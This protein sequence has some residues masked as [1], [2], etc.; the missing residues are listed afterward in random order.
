MHF[1]IKRYLSD[2]R[3]SQQRRSFLQ[4]ARGRSLGRSKVDAIT[5]LVSAS[6]PNLTKENVSVVDQNGNLLSR[7]NGSAESQ[8]V[9]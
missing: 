8:I 2:S 3:L 4:L 7:S 5:H 6:I 1:L 9:K